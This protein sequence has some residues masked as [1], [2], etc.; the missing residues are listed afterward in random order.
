MR[1]LICGLAL[2]LL[3][4][5]V[6]AEPI[7]RVA[8]II[9]DLG[10]SLSLGR[11]AVDLPGALT[12]AVLPDLAHSRELAE[13]AHRDGKEVMLHLPMQTA[14]GRLMGPGGLHM[15]MTREGFARKVKANLD[16]VPYAAGVNNHMG[17]LL[18][19]HPGAMRWLMQD[20]KSLGSY[21]FVDS[22]TD[23]RTVARDLAR[24]EGLANAE[25]DVFL[26]N[27]R[28]A[29]YIRGQMR[30]LIREARRNGTAIGI[31]HPYP[32][33]IKVLKEMLPR[34]ADYGIELVPVSELVEPRS[35]QLWHAS[36]SPLQTVAKNSKR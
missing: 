28:N 2:C 25:R 14:D 13:R 4:V 24:E 27:Q 8:I 5:V 1:R 23:V 21:Y 3:A 32:E 29:D 34:L 33:T 22:R 31:G 6:Q 11:K 12:C 30:Q 19:R 26:D 9:D 17:S 16:A 10:N 20:L 7:A 36:S 15:D 35:E 18:T